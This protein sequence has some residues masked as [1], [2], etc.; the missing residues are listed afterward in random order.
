MGARHDDYWRFALPE[1]YINVE[2]MQSPAH[3]AEFLHSIDS[4]DDL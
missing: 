2:D 4:N 1:S 3:L